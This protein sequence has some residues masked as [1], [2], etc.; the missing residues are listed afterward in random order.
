MNAPAWP[1]SLARSNALGYLWYIKW[2]TVTHLPAAG[3]DTQKQH[4]QQERNDFQS[5]PKC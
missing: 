5:H 3:W 4:T 1:A 2:T